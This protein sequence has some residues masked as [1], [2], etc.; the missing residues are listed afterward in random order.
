LAAGRSARWTAGGAR[1]LKRT[2]AGSWYGLVLVAAFA[3]P[4]GDGGEIERLTTE[5]RIEEQDG[6][7]TNVVRI[8]REI[9]AQVEH[10]HG[11]GASETADALDQL[12]RRVVMLG[13]KAEAETLHREALAIREKVFG[14]D[15]L[16]TARSFFRLGV[17]LKNSRYERTAAESWLKRCLEIRERHADRDPNALV[18]VLTELGWF[19]LRYNQHGTAE[20]LLARACGMVNT[21]QANPPERHGDSF[22][23]LGWVHYHIG[24]LV[25][26]AATFGR[27]YELKQIRPGPEHWETMEIANALAAVHRE[28]GQF[29]EALKLSELALRVRERSFGPNHAKVAES[30]CGLGITYELMGDPARA[31]SCFERAIPILDRVYAGRGFHLMEAYHHLSRVLHDL[32]DLAEAERHGETA[33]LLSETEADARAAQSAAYFEHLA[34][35]KLDLGKAAEALRHALRAR[36]LRE[37]VFGEALGFT[38]ERQRLDLLARSMRPHLLATLGAARPIAESVLRTKGMV[39]DSLLEEALLARSSDDAEALSLVNQIGERR[40]GEA[41]LSSATACFE[42]Q[43]A[44]EELEAALAR[45]IAGS[46]AARRALRVSVEEVRETLPAATALIDFVR[47]DRYVGRRRVEPCYGALTLSRTTGPEWVELGRADAID[48]Q[49]RT[50]QHALRNA[51][52]DAP[53]AAELAKLRGLVWTAIE[54]MLPLGTDKVILSPDGELALVSFAVLPW[55]SESVLGERFWISYVSTGRDLLAPEPPTSEDAVQLCILANPDFDATSVQQLPSR[56]SWP[57]MRGVTDCEVRGLSFKPLPGAEREGRLLHARAGQLG[58]TEVELYVGNQ[59]TEGALRSL[60]GPAVLHVATHGF[61]FPASGSGRDSDLKVASGGARQEDTA[62]AMLR[63]GLLLAG[64]RR[65]IERWMAGETVSPETDGIVTADEVATLNLCG[66]RLVVLP[67]CDSGAGEIRAGEGVL[68]LRR[69][70]LKA[71][72][73]NLMLTLWP[74][75]DESTAPMMA[76]FYERLHSGGNAPQAM[77]EMQRH[78]LR[79][80][81]KER[82]AAEAC[83]LAGPF[84]VSFQGRGDLVMGPAR[85]K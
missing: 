53:L 61:R 24:D 20:T 70:F 55:D 46:G 2:I 63:T 49:V 79:K 8:A 80:L 25:R 47:Y 29:G 44:L 82:G 58:F 57:T 23:A 11:R 5:L 3:V 74:V 30:L 54:R 37:T 41:A 52:E 21:G 26:A 17:F 73:R 65:S 33:V 51:V 76:E 42:R 10:E 60:D 14:P 84:I 69:G 4:A 75:D 67:A 1:F 36:S 6:R 68:G 66:T 28:H 16:E 83:R 32:G 27:A 15:H 40:S 45:R 56:A 50:V 43:P 7:W 85:F 81:R 39:L 18:D 59:A 38:S 78:W 31:R 13:S 77:A 64:A 71:G 72:A 12:G 35:L 62:Q 22:Y 19:Y 48:R 9:L 34:E